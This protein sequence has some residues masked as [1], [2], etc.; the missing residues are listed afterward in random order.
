MDMTLCS[1]LLME[2]ATMILT[3]SQQLKLKMGYKES[4]SQFQKW[5]FTSPLTSLENNLE[6]IFRAVKT[7][8]FILF[9]TIHYLT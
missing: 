6:E 4:K 9:A 8:E 7:Q 5:L 3:L 1:K 2:D